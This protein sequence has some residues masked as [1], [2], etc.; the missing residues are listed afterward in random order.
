MSGAAATSFACWSSWAS[1]AVKR[2][3]ELSNRSILIRSRR[4]PAP[5]VI[6]ARQAAMP[7]GQRE[8]LT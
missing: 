2:S 8:N 3:G 4:Y 6:Q 7:E 5:A 1:N